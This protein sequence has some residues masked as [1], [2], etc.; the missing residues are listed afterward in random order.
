MIVISRNGKTTIITGWR[1]WLLGT[2]AVVA[3]WLLLA[4]IAFVWIGV[5]MTIGAILLLV[6]PAIL[7]AVW[8]QLW[9]GKAPY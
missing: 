3:A 8:L 7:I 6:M 5:A 9:M 4:I 1:A 2:I